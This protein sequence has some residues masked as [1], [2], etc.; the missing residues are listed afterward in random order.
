MQFKIYHA[1][2]DWRGPPRSIEQFDTLEQLLAFVDGQP[3][4]IIIG[5]RYPM[6]DG[7]ARRLI[8]YDDYME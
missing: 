3:H 2:D 1:N 4:E 5:R 8:V 7:D 6:F